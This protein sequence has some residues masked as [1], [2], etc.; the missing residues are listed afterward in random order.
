VDTNYIGIKIGDG[1]FYPVM[2]EDFQGKKRFVLTTVRDDQESMQIDFYRSP[3][4]KI[5][6]SEYIGSLLIESI[7]ANSKGAAEI[8]VVV[9]VSGDKSLNAVA[10]NLASGD[11]HSLSVNLANLSEQE[12]YEIPEF[13]LDETMP[14]KDYTDETESPRTVGNAQTTIDRPDS[15]AVHERKKGGVMGKILIIVLILCVLGG[16]G[17]LGYWLVTNNIISFGATAQTSPSPEP[18]KSPEPTKEAALVKTEAPSPQPTA[19]PVPEETPKPAFTPTPKK[20]TGKTRT[21]V[22]YLI[23]AGDTL[24][25]LAEAFYRNPWMYVKIFKANRKIIKDPDW[26]FTGSRIFIPKK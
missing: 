14:P 7:E 1:S 19:S 9:G 10:K 25:D 8:E 26:I 24:W 15:G 16:L 6:N 13:E 18:V 3:D 21:G 20:T 4:K 11:K 5:G 22:Y 23:K 2:E 17:F 12:I